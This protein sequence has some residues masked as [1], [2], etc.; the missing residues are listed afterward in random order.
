[1]FWIIVCLQ[2]LT[3]LWQIWYMN[4]WSVHDQMNTKFEFIYFF[5]VIQIFVGYN[6]T[7]HIEKNCNNT[8]ILFDEFK[9]FK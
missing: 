1:M 5:L 7:I 8:I 6:V 3:I 2:N 4:T 9:W